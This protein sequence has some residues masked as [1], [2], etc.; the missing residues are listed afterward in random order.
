MRLATLALVLV[1]VLAACDAARRD[2]DPAPPETTS[3]TAPDAQPAPPKKWRRRL[4]PEEYRVTRE[5]GTERPFT[6]RY[7]NTKTPGTYVC[8]GCDQILFR[9]TEKYD[10]GCG[11]P[12]FW[13]DAKDGNVVTEIDRSL[14]MVREEILCSRCGAH[15]GHVFDDG[16]PPTGRRYCVN[17]AA[18]RLVEDDPRER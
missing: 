4:S 10:S 15:L 7:W 8:V 1:P 5:K 9:S 3:M 13:D 2:P 18:L 17:S 12:S 6:G 14:G 11:W 16:P